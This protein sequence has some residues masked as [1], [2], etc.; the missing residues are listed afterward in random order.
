MFSKIDIN[1]YM[2]KRAKK[3]ARKKRAAR[4]DDSK[5][6]D[7]KR[8][9]SKSRAKSAKAPVPT[10][11]P[12]APAAEAGVSLK[13]GEKKKSKPL[14]REALEKVFPDTRNPIG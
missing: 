10:K 7:S 13:L 2:A 12:E 11:K 14:G 4:K 6:R 3:K 1:I 5:K 9:V 8:A